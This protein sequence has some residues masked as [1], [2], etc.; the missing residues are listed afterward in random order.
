MSGLNPLPAI[1]YDN[2]LKKAPTTY[3]IHCVS[4]SENG[5]FPTLFNRKLEVL[6]PKPCVFSCWENIYQKKGG[7]PNFFSNSIPFH[8]KCQTHPVE[9]SFCLFPLASKQFHQQINHFFPLPPLS[10]PRLALGLT[11]TKKP[12]RLIVSY[13]LRAQD[14]RWRIPPWTG[15]RAWTDGWKGKNGRSKNNVGGDIYIYIHIYNDLES[16]NWNIHL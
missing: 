14:L 11:Y 1:Q 10:S 6:K 8:L 9:A 7:A 2:S 13:R 5:F 15:G 12:Q 3:K 4:A 16:S